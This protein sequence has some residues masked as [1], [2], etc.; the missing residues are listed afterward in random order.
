MS[1]NSLLERV[2]RAR[3]DRLK[4][5]IEKRSLL[6][7]AV[8]RSFMPLAINFVTQLGSASITVMR[9]ASLHLSVAVHA[10]DI[11]IT[12]S[13][14]TLNDLLFSGS[15]DEFLLAERDG[16]IRFAAYSLK[17]QKAISY[18]RKMFGA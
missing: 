4:S 14:E 11:T 6:E 16:R 5:K 9:D 17:G 8:F 1:L 18:V 7:K 15:E 12:S 13:H 10:P 3:G 2:I